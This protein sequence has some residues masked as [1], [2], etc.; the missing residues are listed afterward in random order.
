MPPVYAAPNT[1]AAAAPSGLSADAAH[2]DRQREHGEQRER[3]ERRWTDAAGRI[4]ERE[5]AGVDQQRDQAGDDDADV[6]QRREAGGSRQPEELPRAEAA[7]T[8]RSAASGAPPTS[9]MAIAIGAA[10]TP[11]RIRRVSS[12]LTLP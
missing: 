4:V 12:E 1:V 5:V 8:A 2:P 9:K 3:R 6:V 11:N 10:I 7:A